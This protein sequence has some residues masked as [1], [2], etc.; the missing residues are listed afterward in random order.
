[1][2]THKTFKHMKQKILN[3][4]HILGYLLLIAGAVLQF[5]NN[6]TAPYIFT[7]GAIGYIVGKM[8]NLPQTDDFRIKRLNNLMA[9]GALAM[10]GAVYLLWE[11]KNSWVIALTISVFID[12]YTS[13]RYPKKESNK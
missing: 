12:L 9:L 8:F 5:I 7:A 3:I 10:A 1:M 11:D 2:E 13:F 6:I 4:V